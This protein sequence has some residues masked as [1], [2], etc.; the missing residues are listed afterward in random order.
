VGNIKLPPGLH[1]LMSE[2]S[3]NRLAYYLPRWLNRPETPF[4]LMR[5]KMWRNPPGT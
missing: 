5:Q 4:T 1:D 3:A 2:N